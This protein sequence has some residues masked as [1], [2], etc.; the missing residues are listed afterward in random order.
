METSWEK[1]KKKTKEIHKLAGEMDALLDQLS[2]KYAMLD[3]LIIDA[4]QVTP[5]KDTSL[6][7]SPLGGQKILFYIKSHLIHKGI[8]VAR[9]YVGN[10]SDFEPFQLKIQKGLDWLLKLEGVDNERRSE[11]K[12]KS[13]SESRAESNT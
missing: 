9:D 2:K 10:P 5:K 13:E 8:M 11:S 12:S 6:A 7:S 3:K 4:Y 1:S